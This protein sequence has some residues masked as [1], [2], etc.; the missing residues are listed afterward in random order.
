MDCGTIT[1]VRIRP[2][3]SIEAR[4]MESKKRIVTT[5]SNSCQVV[6]LDP[7]YFENPDNNNSA[8]GTSPISSPSPSRERKINER[9]FQFDYCFNSLSRESDP[10]SEC[11]NQQQIYETIGA[12][13]IENVINGYNCSLFA[14]GLPLSLSHL[15]L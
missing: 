11:V 4:A 9:K 14:Y 10:R 13:L 2:L 15:P 12:P 6:L 1:A 3:S 8:A 5:V 7:C